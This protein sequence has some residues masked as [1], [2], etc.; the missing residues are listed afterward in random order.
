MVKLRVIALNALQET[1]RR[2][3][4]YIVLFL[5]VI[6]LALTASQM[7]FLHMATAAG[8]NKIAA[9]V[10]LKTV[11]AMLGIWSAAAFFLALFLGA[12]GISAEISS[13]TI[14]H[15]LSRPIER[16]V[17][18]FGRWLGLL[19]FLWGFFIIG[20]AASMIFAAGFHV[21]HTSVIWLGFAQKLIELTFY[22][23]VGLAFS[24]FMPPVLAGGCALMLT[25]LPSMLHQT[26]QH[27][28][29][30]WRSLATLAY[31]LG[32]AQ[33]PA[34]LVA[35]SFTKE[36]L[37]M[38]YAIYLQVMAENLLYAVAVLLIAAFIFRR[39]EVRVR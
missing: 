1:L 12:I 23:G 10:A 20:V 8:E 33:G 35:Q 36:L 7:V 25:L 39:R 30:L 27:P 26:M 2:K 22:S 24:V 31:Y 4:L 28:N 34:D 19:I 6:V 15:I 18:L 17:Y 5:T 37:N 21:F 11:Q 38:P 14:V 13:K 16:W 9:S 3:V 29:A 32:P